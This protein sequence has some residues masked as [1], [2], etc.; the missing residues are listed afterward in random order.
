MVYNIEMIKQTL[1]QLRTEA[2]KILKK[3]KYNFTFRSCWKCNGAHGHLKESP[4]VIHC[5]GCGHWYY[6]GKDIT[7]K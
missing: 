2:E 5:F 4:H 3:K 6:K 7:I 1:K